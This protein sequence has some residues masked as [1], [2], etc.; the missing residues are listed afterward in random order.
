V[1][2]EAGA[3][4][5][6]GDLLV[7]MNRAVYQVGRTQWLMTA[8]AAVCD[9]RAGELEFANAG[10]NF[11]YV[12]TPVAGGEC[13][14]QQLVA[15]G[16]ALGAVSSTRF[17]TQRRPLGPTD[18]LFLYTDGLVDQANA[19]GEPY[20]DKRMRAVLAAPDDDATG[21]PDRLLADFGRHVG[22][23]KVGD[24]ITLVVVSGE[25]RVEEGRAL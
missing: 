20:G 8:F 6:P 14:L 4:V 1:L 17:A 5:D 24:D 9:A 12:L 7:Q 2:A 18:R 21:L 3:S 15:R 23:A 11:P 16:N 13:K 22:Q 19:T 10:Q 25:G